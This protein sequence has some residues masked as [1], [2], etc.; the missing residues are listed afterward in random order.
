[1]IQ[2]QQQDNHEEYQQ[3]SF[4]R[5]EELEQHGIAKSD[6]QKLKAG[7][8]HTIESIAH[9]TMKKLIEVKGI[10]E[11]KA[12]KLKDM[13]RAQQLVSLGFQTASSRLECMKDLIMI[14]TGSTELD[15]LLGGGIE[16]G[17]LTEIFG[18]FRTGK[19][20]LC[21]TLCVTAQRPLDQGGAEGRVIY[22]DTEGTFRPQKLVAIAERFR[23]NPEEVLDNIICARAHNS[24][25]Q[26]ELLADAAALMSDSR[27]AL[28][29]VDS[30]TALY[31]TDYMGR[32]EL[33]ERQMHLGQFLRQLT[34]LAEE[35]GIAVVL[36]N[37]VETVNHI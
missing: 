28:L 10:S 23:M 31:R 2:E 25:Q 5:I 7:G 21:H 4:R 24:E 17:S 30:A 11:Q 18:E 20:Q 36:T 34:R 32:G 37:Q 3:V 6:I 26:L 1:M 12:Q 15:N 9:T 33:S 13:I 19:T 8:F 14:S 22:V 27:Y 16:T 35:F 29:I